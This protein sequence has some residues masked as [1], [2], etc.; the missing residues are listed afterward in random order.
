MPRHAREQCACPFGPHLVQVGMAD[1]AKGN[2]DLHVVR[3]GCAAGD[4]QGFEGLVAR[5]G[6]VSVNGHGVAPFVGWR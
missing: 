4:L 1:A 5:M 6:T 3:T 2:V